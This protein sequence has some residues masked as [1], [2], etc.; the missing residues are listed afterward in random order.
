MWRIWDSDV[1]AAFALFILLSF[2][3]HFTA[4]S[5]VLIGPQ[6]GP[7]WERQRHMMIESLGGSWMNN[8]LFFQAKPSTG[9]NW[10][11]W[12]EKTTLFFAP[13]IWISR[14]SPGLIFFHCLFAFDLPVLLPLS[15]RRD[16]RS[17]MNLPNHLAM[18]KWITKNSWMVDTKK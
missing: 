18:A 8:R 14:I 15:R 3:L 11:Y 6:C 7:S 9:I 13:S 2:T 12:P 16:V 1:T 17:E 5:L 4:L 10:I